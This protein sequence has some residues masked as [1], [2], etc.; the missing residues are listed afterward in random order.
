MLKAFS[1]R[2]PPQKKELLLPLQ[3]DGQ[4]GL[5]ELMDLLP[6]MSRR[7]LVAAEVLV[8]MPLYGQNHMH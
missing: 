4:R 6:V 7:V 5:A 1:E 3:V 2:L 8:M